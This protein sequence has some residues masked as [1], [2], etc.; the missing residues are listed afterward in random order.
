MICFGALEQS[1]FP[2]PGLLQNSAKYTPEARTWHRT[3]NEY[4]TVLYIHQYI[5]KPNHSATA[6]ESVACGDIPAV[7]RAMTRTDVMLMSP[8]NCISQNVLCL[9]LIAVF[10][11]VLL[12]FV[13]KEFLTSCWIN[14]VSLMQ[15]GKS[16]VWCVLDKHCYW[17]QKSFWDH[18]NL[19]LCFEF[20]FKKRT[21]KSMPWK[22]RIVWK[23]TQMFVFCS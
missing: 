4:A 10:Y 5:G 2:S 13:R 11:S 3:I 18:L 15:F 7:L 16:S 6:E 1:L 12:S 22:P 8:W 14:A 21:L 19:H 23:A 20:S 9:D 17:A